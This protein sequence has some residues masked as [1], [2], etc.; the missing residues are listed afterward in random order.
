MRN[1]VDRDIVDGILK[2]ERMKRRGWDKKE[3][4]YKIFNTNN[5]II[6]IKSEK[7]KEKIKDKILFLIIYA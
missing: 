4:K 3:K 1:I 6:T 2:F 7:I 5:F